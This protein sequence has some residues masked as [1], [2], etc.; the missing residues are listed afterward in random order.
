MVVMEFLA[1]VAVVLAVVLEQIMA[2]MV[3]VV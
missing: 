3:V 1:A 2:V